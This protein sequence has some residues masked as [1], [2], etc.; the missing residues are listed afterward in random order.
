MSTAVPA[1]SLPYVG[2]VIRYGYL[3]RDQHLRGGSGVATVNRDPK[4]S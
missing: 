1:P 3:R 4:P 2:A